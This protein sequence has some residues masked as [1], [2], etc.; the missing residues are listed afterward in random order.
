MK[1]N[2]IVFISNGMYKLKAIGIIDGDYY[3]DS[4][5]SIRFCQFRKVKWLH[6][7]LDIP[8]RKVYG[9]NFCNRLFI[10]F[11]TGK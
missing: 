11:L 7:D 6:K 1:K 3:F 10:I 2:D 9:S 4:N 8:V 5:T